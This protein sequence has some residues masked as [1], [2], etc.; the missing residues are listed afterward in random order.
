MHC[1]GTSA[2]VKEWVSRMRRMLVWLTPPAPRRGACQ[3]HLPQ[4]WR[5]AAAGACH[6]Y[7]T[8]ARAW[9]VPSA[10]CCTLCRPGTRRG[11]GPP[12]PSQPLHSRAAGSAVLLWAQWPRPSPSATWEGGRKGIK[13]EA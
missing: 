12:S 7:A 10:T 9:C 13:L 2:L 8:S 1:V 11:S 4:A 5:A 6:Y 3:H